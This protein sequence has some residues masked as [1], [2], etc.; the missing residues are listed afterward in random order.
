MG[1]RRQSSIDSTNSDQL[2]HGT[3][4]EYSQR[5]KSPKESI[6]KVY[7]PLIS[8]L[9]KNNASFEHLNGL[10]RADG[11]KNVLTFVKKPGPEIY[12]HYSPV[13]AEPLLEKKHG[14]QRFV[15]IFTHSLFHGS[16]HSS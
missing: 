14:V 16:L 13:E 4:L 2:E 7:E 11:V 9:A 8:T 15:L 6:F 3:H 10:Y 5:L 1:S 12:G